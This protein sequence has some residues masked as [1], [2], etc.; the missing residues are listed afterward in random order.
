MPCLS[1][2]IQAL[3][4]K[5]N[6]HRLLRSIIRGSPSQRRVAVQGVRIK[7]QGDED[8]KHISI[9]AVLEHIAGEAE[10]AKP[11]DMKAVASEGIAAF[12]HAYSF[13]RPL[14]STAYASLLSILDSVNAWE[15]A[16]Q[17]YRLYPAQVWPQL[18]RQEM[19][20]QEWSNFPK[21]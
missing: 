16:P 15:L 19:H 21:A 13:G 12:Q 3:R 10:R 14:S 2:H 5:Q 4:I 9:E 6:S 20:K 8:N 1:R 11:E 7:Y 18:Y 17:L